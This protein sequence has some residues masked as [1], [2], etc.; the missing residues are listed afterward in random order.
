MAESDGSV[1]RFRE[2]R[3]AIFLAIARHP[4]FETGV[5][6]L[7]GAAGGATVERLFVAARLDFETFAPP[8]HFFA[9]PHLLDHFRS[10]EDEIIAER[11]D[12]HEAAFLGHL[13]DSG[14]EVVDVT[15]DDANDEMSAQA[16]RTIA[17]MQAG[18]DVVY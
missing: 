18:V 6:N 7:G 15:K 3:D 14:L 8:G 17:A 9:M 13:E 4:E 12:E 1:G 5:A 2:V 10:E 11:G 16:D